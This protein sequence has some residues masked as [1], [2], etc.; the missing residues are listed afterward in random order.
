[1]I[2]SHVLHLQRKKASQ[3][4]VWHSVNETAWPSGPLPL[5]GDEFLKEIDVVVSSLLL[6]GGG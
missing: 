3:V 6:H 4:Y 1:M 2:R 5:L